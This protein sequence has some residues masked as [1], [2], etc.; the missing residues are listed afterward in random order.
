[1]EGGWYRPHDR[2]RTFGER[3]GNDKSDEDDDNEYS[4]DG[5]IPDDEDKYNGG[6]QT[7]KK[8]NNQQP[9]MRGLNG[10]EMRYEAQPAGGAVGA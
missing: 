4:V 7:T 8:H 5:D 1:M 10:G 9:K 2:A 3:D 6:H